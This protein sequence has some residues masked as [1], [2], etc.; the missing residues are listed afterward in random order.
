GD[1][2]GWGLE[3]IRRAAK[4][5]TRPASSIRL[6]AAPRIAGCSRAY[7]VENA[8]S[9]TMAKYT[10]APEMER[11]ASSTPTCRPTASRTSGSRLDQN[12]GAFELNL[13]LSSGRAA[14]DGGGYRVSG[15]QQ[16]NEPRQNARSGIRPIPTSIVPV[17]LGRPDV[18]Q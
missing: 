10:S 12:S 16:Y 5:R 4:I 14:R 15:L 7:S 18:S 8:S 13:I 17:H 2:T 11:L 3:M 1:P 6:P 9:T